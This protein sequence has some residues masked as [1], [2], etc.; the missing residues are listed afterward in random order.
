M[1][2][3][4]SCG[5]ISG[6]MNGGRRDDDPHEGKPQALPRDHVWGGQQLNELSDPI[7]NLHMTPRCD[8]ISFGSFPIHST[9]HCREVD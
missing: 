9:N 2:C 1:A 4:D 3:Y 5:R 8:L 6:A 7:H